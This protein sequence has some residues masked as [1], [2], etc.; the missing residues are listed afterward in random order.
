LRRL[1]APKTAPVVVPPQAPV[2]PPALK[3][4]ARRFSSN[5]VV[6]ECDPAGLP[7]FTP[8]PGDAESE[9]HLKLCENVFLLLE[10]WNLNGCHEVTFSDFRTHSTVK[11][12][13]DSMI[14][15][16]LGDD[17][18][19]GWFGEFTDN[20]EGAESRAQEYIPRQALVFVNLA[21]QKLQAS[22]ALSEDSRQTA[23]TSYAA[24]SEA[25]KRKRED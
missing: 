16:L 1:Q 5:D 24:M 7:T 13:F 3:K 17:L 22:Y 18:W 21:L 10:R 6:S 4:R 20:E 19:K 12:R 23:K 11:N 25:C 8:T 14:Y 9:Q 15:E 2:A